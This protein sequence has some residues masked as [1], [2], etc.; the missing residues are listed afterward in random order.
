MQKLRNLLI[1]TLIFAMLLSFAGCNRQKE[2]NNATSQLESNSNINTTE[3]NITENTTENTTSKPKDQLT[4]EDVIA[5]A[6]ENSA[7]IKSYDLNSDTNSSMTYLGF[8]ITYTVA[9]KGTAFVEP[10][11]MMTKSTAVVRNFSTTNSEYYME[12]VGNTVYWYSRTNNGEWTKQ[13]NNGENRLN[14]LKMILLCLNSIENMSKSNDMVNGNNAYRIDGM[15]SGASVENIVNQS[16]LVNSL[17]SMGGG[18]E[19]DMTG[20]FQGLQDMSIT[21][22]IDENTYYPVQFTMEITEISKRI[23]DRMKASGTMPNG[24]MLRN[25]QIVT[26]ET[27]TTLT[28]FNNASDFQIPSEARQGKMNSEQ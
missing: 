9:S 5:Y 6:I 21:L 28:N 2:E 10:M 11:K 16:G 13:E 12:G 7:S 19:I 24:S 14:I 8:P 17:S 22:W 20:V 26:Y 27:L 15:V 23:L 4:A 1:F 3:E 18:A 25:V